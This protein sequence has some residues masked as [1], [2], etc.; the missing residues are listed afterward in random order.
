MLHMKFIQWKVS[1]LQMQAHVSLM[2]LLH[3]KLLNMLKIQ[4]IS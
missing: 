1:K 2:L 3:L 4:N